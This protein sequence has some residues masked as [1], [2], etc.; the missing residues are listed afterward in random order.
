MTRLLISLACATGLPGADASQ[1]ILFNRAPGQG[2][3]QAQPESCGRAAFDEV[4]AHFPNDPDQSARTGLTHIFPV[5]RTPP[6]VTEKDLRTFLDAAEQT[7]TPI[8]AQLDT[9]HWWEA[10][11]G[12]WNLQSDEATLDFRWPAPRERPFPAAGQYTRAC[13]RRSETAAP[14]GQM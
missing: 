6:D 5:F 1:Y 12:L 13:P 4:L 14:W 7:S 9:E 10:R 3:D 11:P 8:V 2:M